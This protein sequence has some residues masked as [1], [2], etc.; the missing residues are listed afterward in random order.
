MAES[1]EQIEIMNVRAMWQN[2]ALDFTPW[3][4]E[5]ISFLGEAIGKNLK[6]DPR[7][8]VVV[9]P[10]RLDILAEDADTGVRVAVENQL[11]WTDTHHLGQLITYATGCDARVSV[12]IATEF[13]YEYA[14]ALHQ[15][16]VWTRDE[17]EFFGV[18]VDV[19]NTPGEHRLSPRFQLVVYPGGW[20]KGLTLQ[21][22]APMEPRA[23]MYC[24]F[25]Q[26]LINALFETG[27][28]NSARQIWG[29][30]GRFFPSQFGGDTGFAGYFGD[31]E[32]KVWVVFHYRGRDKEEASLVFNN[33]SR[34]RTKIEKSIAALPGE[35]WEWNEHRSYSFFS[36]NLVREGSIEDSPEKLR[37]IRNWMR[38][39][40][41]ELKNTIE[42]LVEDVHIELGLDDEA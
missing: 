34:F 9:G 36:V 11:E 29:N 4:A 18:K 15:L 23:Q 14:E 6:E 40:L 2:E 8:E 5:N 35:K 39:R 20:D 38:Q 37:E 10:L 21:R 19:S 42:P 24:D 30:P 3:L 26:P 27:F 25:Y 41:V 1:D 32:K 28:A 17:Y 16:N 7:T 22:D 12:W 33:L 31:N 13:R